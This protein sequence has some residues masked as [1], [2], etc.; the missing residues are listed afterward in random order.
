M[1]KLFPLALLA[2]TLAS[3]SCMRHYPT[4]HTAYRLSTLPTPYHG[5]KV[6]VFFPGERPAD[7]AFVKVSV[8]EQKREGQVA[9]A[10]L[11]QDLQQKAQLQG[12]D[13]I[14]LLDKQQSTRLQD[15]ATF[16]QAVAELIFK[17]DILDTYSSVTTHELAAVG[18]KYKRNLGYLPE[19]VQAKKIYNV[20]GNQK[21]LLATIPVNNLGIP[22]EPISATP[23]GKH[24][25]ELF[26]H[27]YDLAH[28]LQEENQYWKFATQDGRLKKRKL[29]S[30]KGNEISKK[31]K[32]D[33]GAHG[34]PEA[35]RL[36]TGPS[37]FLET[38]QLIYDEQKRVVEK[39][40]LRDKQ[41][42]V[43]EVNQLGASG[44]VLAT[45]HYQMQDG[46]EVPFL[47]TV[48]EYYEPLASSR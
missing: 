12:M 21:E 43:R 14:L 20:Q 35:V 22:Q 24:L 16:G 32:V 44:K 46:K 27:R 17:T 40:I 15:D 23:E 4:Y 42:F 25:Y 41:L 37:L 19:H 11:V 6:E 7:T 1:N 10:T 26:V 45:T 33:Y 48:Y 36:E 38:I 30:E 18:I 29:R 31:V 9:Y 3:T 2:I 5:K 39:K 34:L 47:K 8:L 28:L 13:A